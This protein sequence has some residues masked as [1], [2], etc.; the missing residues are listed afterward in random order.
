[1]SCRA[2]GVADH[3]HT[4]QSETSPGKGAQGTVRRRLPTTCT[5]LPGPWHGAWLETGSYCPG[6]GLMG[7]F[8][9]AQA[10]VPDLGCLGC[11]TRHREPHQSSPVSWGGGC[12]PNSRCL[13]AAKGQR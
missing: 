6:S 5:A 2:T 12:P 8:C 1:M 4:T 11:T 7:T 10:E 9:L 3:G 13:E